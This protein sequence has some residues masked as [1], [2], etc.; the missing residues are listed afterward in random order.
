MGNWDDKTPD[1]PQTLPELGFAVKDINRRLAGGNAKFSMLTKALATVALVA[2]GS[3]GSALTL[4][5]RAGTFTAESNE[6]R[7]RQREQAVQLLQLEGRLRDQTEA[8]KLMAKDVEGQRKA[9]ERIEGALA[10]Q[11]APARRPRR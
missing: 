1:N 9:L 6:T 8:V 4:A 10:E 11:P 3:L 2:L 7:E 5:Y